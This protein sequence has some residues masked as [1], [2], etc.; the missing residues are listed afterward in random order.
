MRH[1]K[2]VALL[3][4]VLP[5]AAP[6]K[7]KKTDVPAVFR[8]ATYVY[9]ESPEGDLYRPGLYPADREAIADVQDALRDW[10]RYALTAR[11]DQA[12]L[13]FVV[14]KGRIASGR[15]GGDISMG[16]PLPPTQAPGHGPGQTGP[17]QTG[18]GPAGSGAG[19]ETGV[20][21]G[22]EDDMLRV[23]T[24]ST[25]GKLQAI[26]WDRTLTDG[27][28]EP[29]LILFKQLKAAVDKAYPSTTASQPSKP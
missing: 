14:R 19:I 22:P 18:S 26:V 20:D 21:V 23:Y 28:D 1:K 11:R 24:L 25:E 5:A 4:V 8:N 2:F 17:G 16:Q 27:L 13:I 12:E 6:A 3:L 15:I 10:N 9:V 29:Q 7:T